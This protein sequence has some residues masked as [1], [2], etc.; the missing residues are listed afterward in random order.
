MAAPLRMART[1]QPAGGRPGCNQSNAP[2]SAVLLVGA[3]LLVVAPPAAPAQHQ[4]HRGKAQHGSPRDC[5]LRRWGHRC[6]L[7]HDRRRWVPGGFRLNW[8]RM[9]QPTASTWMTLRAA[10]TLSPP[11][12]TDKTLTPRRTFPWADRGPA[13]LGGGQR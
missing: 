4:G 7:R 9:T 2:V 8:S 1:V 5:R 13:A 11:P 6:C 3:A 10:V 12:L